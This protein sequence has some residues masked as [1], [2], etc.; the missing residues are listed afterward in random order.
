MILAAVIF[1]AVIL[2]ALILEALNEANRSAR[3]RRTA[4]GDATPGIDGSAPRSPARGG[5]PWA[6]GGLMPA[7]LEQDSRSG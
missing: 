1:E 3:H 6:G 4:G 7:A 5:P 2:E